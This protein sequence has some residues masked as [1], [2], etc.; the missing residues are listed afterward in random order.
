M[1]EVEAQE[2]RE[3]HLRSLLEALSWRIVATTT[4]AMIALPARITNP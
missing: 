3:S 4:T 2:Y 1:V